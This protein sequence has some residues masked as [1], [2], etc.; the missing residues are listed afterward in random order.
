MSGTET[1]ASTELPNYVTEDS[2]LIMG[3]SLFTDFLRDEHHHRDLGDDLIEPGLPKDVA[4][5]S[6]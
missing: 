1:A 6:K 4:I 2:K 3:D 5:A